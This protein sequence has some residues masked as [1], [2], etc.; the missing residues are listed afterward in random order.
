MDL[1]RGIILFDLALER[2]ATFRH[3][4]FQVFRVEEMVRDLVSLFVAF[5]Y[6]MSQGPFSGSHQRSCAYVVRPR[7]WIAYP[8][9]SMG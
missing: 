5:S 3:V 7:Q 8:S 6:K 1:L 2:G 4:H 9:A